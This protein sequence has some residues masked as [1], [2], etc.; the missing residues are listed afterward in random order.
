[1]TPTHT[2]FARKPYVYTDPTDRSTL[3][4]EGV[5]VAFFVMHVVTETHQ[6]MRGGKEYFAGDIWNTVEWVHMA[7]FIAVTAD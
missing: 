7:A 6:F 4:F 2:I 1:M 3:I 5:L